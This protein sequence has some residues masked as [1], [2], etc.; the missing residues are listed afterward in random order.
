MKED[1]AKFMYKTWNWFFDFFVK[2]MNEWNIKRRTKQVKISYEELS[3]TKKDKVLKD[4]IDFADQLLS[5][6]KKYEKK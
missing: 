4:N 5:I 1:F 6:I 3:Q 2:N